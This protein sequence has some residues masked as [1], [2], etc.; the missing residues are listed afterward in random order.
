MKNYVVRKSLYIFLN[1]MSTGCYKLLYSNSHSVLDS[2][3]SIPLTIDLSCD[4]YFVALA[5]CQVFGSGIVCG[6]CRNF[7]GLYSPLAFNVRC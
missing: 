5:G 1:G 6:R 3:C 2:V 4:S 7:L